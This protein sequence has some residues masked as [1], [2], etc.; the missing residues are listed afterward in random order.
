[1]KIDVPCQ[2]GHQLR[3]TYLMA[4]SREDLVRR[5]SRLGQVNG[6]ALSDA[7]DHLRDARNRYLMHIEH[8]Q[9]RNY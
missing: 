6:R 9:C 4:L 3:N 2:V 7:H 5:S 8:H 1:M